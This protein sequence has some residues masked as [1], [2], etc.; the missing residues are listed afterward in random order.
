MLFLS[1]CS[2]AL[3]SFDLYFYVHDAILG[4]SAYHPPK[5]PFPGEYHIF[6][7]WLG[8]TQSTIYGP[9]FVAAARLV[10]STFPTLFGKLMALRFVDAICYLLILRG[11][12]A[13]GM[14][15]RIR[16]VAALN[17]GLMLQY[18]S[19]GHNDLMPIV[20]LVWG[21]AVVRTRPALT[22]GLIA[23]A[24]LFKLPYVILG[25]PIVA[26]VRS[27]PARFSGTAIVLAIVASLTWA[28]G[29]T[30]YGDALAGYDRDYHPDVA[31]RVAGALALVLIVSA[32]FRSRRLKSAVW[33]MPTLS[34]ALYSWY[35]IWG[36]P[37][38]LA[39]RRILG[40][41]L[42][43]YPLVAT[44]VGS[45]IERTWE[46]SIALPILVGLSILVSG[47]PAADG[48]SHEE[49]KRVAA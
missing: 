44:L 16:T 4:L 36:L 17:P 9:L 14:P 15:E 40:Y 48:A 20:A 26:T 45:A 31:Q 25:L 7:L 37:Y 47:K 29:G 13:Q 8:G 21:A 43:C 42:V 27:L 6:D 5:V 10:T 39:R 35:F 11:L 38:A 49:S 3:I 32:W 28:V 41:F 12:R 19:D 34:A 30:G 18:V 2:P 1:I 33:I 23:V 22:F 24:G 46:L